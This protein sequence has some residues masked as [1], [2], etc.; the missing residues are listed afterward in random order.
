MKTVRGRHHPPVAALLLLAVA[1]LLVL[2]ALDVRTWQATVQR[3]DLRF[4]VQP[5]ATHLWEPSTILPGDPAGLALATG[6]ITRWRSALQA[7]WYAHLATAPTSEQNDDLPALRAEAQRKL[8]ELVAGAKTTAE[9]SAAANLLGVLAITTPTTPAAENVQSFEQALRQTIEYF[10]Q[11]ITLDPSNT[12]AKQNL[13]LVLRVTRPGKGPIGRHARTGLGFA[14]RQ[15]STDQ[16]G[17]G[18]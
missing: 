16:P 1:G 6:D 9:R 5:G 4:R 2:F 17:N 15:S 3:D 10:Q 14:H 7:F 11:A 12:H 8:Q 18:Y 13:E